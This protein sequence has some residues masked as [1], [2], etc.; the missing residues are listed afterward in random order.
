MVKRA[1]KSKSKTDEIFIQEGGEEMDTSD[2]VSDSLSGVLSNESGG[3]DSEQAASQS[4]PSLRQRMAQEG[5]TSEEK[6]KRRGRPPGSRNQSRRPDEIRLTEEQKNA[7]LVPCFSF[8]NMILER[9]KIEVLDSDE[10]ASGVTAFGP[11]VEKYAPKLGEHSIW[12]PPALW[13]VTVAAMRA[14]GKNASV[15]N[16]GKNVESRES[17]TKEQA[18]ITT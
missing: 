7:L 17:V 13:I 18:S 12:I 15:T 16:D 6:P 5:I 14:G 4:E 9:R 2:S 11:V 3:P 8:V 10:I 1:K